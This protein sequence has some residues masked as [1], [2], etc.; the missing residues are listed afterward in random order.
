MWEYYNG[1]VILITGGSG[2]LGTAIVHR[3]LSCSSVDHIFLLCRGGEEKLRRKWEEFLPLDMVEK[4]CNPSHLT[5][6]NGDILLPG[7]GLSQTELETLRS[8]I[9]I[10]I[11]AASSISLAKRLH[12]LSALI[13]GASEAIAEF[14][15]TCKNLDRFVYVSSAY[16]N[17]H[18]YSRSEAPPSD[19]EI[20]E[21]FYSLEK[22]GNPTI[23]WDAV[24]KHGTSDA[25][26]AED[27]PWAYAYAKHL[28]ERLLLHQ[29]E[30]HSAKEKFLII[31]PSIIG[32]AQNVPF[33]GYSMP[34]STPST[35]VAAVIALDPSWKWKIA[36][37]MTFPEMEVTIDEVPVDVVVDRLLSH[38]A[39][40]AHG[41][42]HAVSG[43]RARVSPEEWLEPVMKLRRIPWT[44]LP[45]WLAVDWKSPKQHPISRLYVILGTSFAFSEDRTIALSQKLE[46][47]HSD[48]QL[49][50][51]VG[52]RERT[53]SRDEHVRHVMDKLAQ[54]SLVAWLIIQVFYRDY[55]R[56]K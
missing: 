34:M 53:F 21:D 49:F 11:H 22:Q 41:C 8:A 54:K 51:R 43:K 18:V 5:I 16:A 52:M 26:E 55:G 32:P 20:K 42:V 1:K 31:R 3:L 48:L 27:F 19:I 14:A 15:F 29:F 46:E 44:M 50:A 28:T 35:I 45:H 12:S 39:I 25:Y 17:T 13:I 56:N 6:L 24:R 9:N 33:P 47:A 2:F 10:I 30:Q 37:R 40:E 36:T 7:M 23:E 4:L 38:L